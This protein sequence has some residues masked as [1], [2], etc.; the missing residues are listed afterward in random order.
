MRNWNCKQEFPVGFGC[1][2][3]VAE[4]LDARDDAVRRKQQA[5]EQRYL[6]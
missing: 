1:G 6:D 5:G 4:N 3:A 2:S